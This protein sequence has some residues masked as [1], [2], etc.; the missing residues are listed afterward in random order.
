MSTTNSK[1]LPPQ[2]EGVGPWIEFEGPY[3]RYPVAPDTKV[4][5]LLR[6]ERE[7]QDYYHE[8]LPAGSYDWGRP[9]VA[10]CVKL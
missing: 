7:K 10:Y 1:W 6:S 8:G 9:C 2:Q 3:G 5:Y 4:G